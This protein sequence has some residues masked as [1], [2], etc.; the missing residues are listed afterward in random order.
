MNKVTA[1]VGM[2][3]VLWW[4][5]AFASLHEAQAQRGKQFPC[6]AE[7]SVQKVAR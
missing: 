7:M 6:L 1:A 3:I 5:A 4:A 2:V